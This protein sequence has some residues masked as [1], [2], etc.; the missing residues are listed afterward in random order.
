MSVIPEFDD[1]RSAFV[2]HLE[3]QN[4]LSNP[5]RPGEPL[6]DLRSQDGLLAEISPP[7]SRDDLQS[8][9]PTHAAGVD[10]L[11]NPPEGVVGSQPVEVDLLQVLL[12]RVFRRFAPRARAGHDPILM[13]LESTL[14]RQSGKL[15]S[16]HVGVP[17]SPRHHQQSPAGMPAATKE[18]PF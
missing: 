17:K 16:I 9:H 3:P 5:L 2:C 8:V 10:T 4:S 6:L 11:G 14:P 13:N 7:S 15:S 1:E 12:R 18:N